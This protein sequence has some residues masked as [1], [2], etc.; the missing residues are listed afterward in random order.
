MA[1]SGGVGRK[2][3]RAAATGG[4]VSYR[5]HLPIGWFSTISLVAVLGIAIVAYSRYEWEHPAAA[6]QPT[7]G[8]KWQAAVGFDICNK[9]QPNLPEPSNTSVEGIT[10]DGSGLIQIDPKNA[11]EAGS[12]ATLGTFASGYPGMILTRSGVQLP[13]KKLWSN[14]ERCGTKPAKLV[15]ESWSS[16]AALTGTVDTGDP[17]L[18]RLRNGQLITVGFVPAGT[19]LPKPPSGALLAGNVTTTATSTTLGKGATSTTLGKSATSTT[20]GKSTSTSTTGK[21]TKTTTSSTAPNTSTTKPSVIAP[22]S[23]GKAATSTTVR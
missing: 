11:G 12:N 1:K 4:K 9:L 20:L 14:G 22:T 16:L 7:V 23:K 18:L 5:G 3:A 6:A 8:T 21:S 13:G 15:V 19:T 2:V 10:T 17:T